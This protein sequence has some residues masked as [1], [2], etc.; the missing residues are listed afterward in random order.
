MLSKFSF[1][2]FV[3]VFLVFSSNVFAQTQSDTQQTYNNMLADAQNSAVKDS[4]GRI[5]QISVKLL[6]DSAT[7]I[8]GLNYDNNNVSTVIDQGG[9]S[10]KVRRDE[11][12]N[13]IGYVFPDGG[14]STIIWDRSDPNKP[15]SIGFEITRPNGT[16]D[17]QLF[18]GN[19]SQIAGPIRPR[20]DACS[21]AIN[22]AG[23]AATAAVVACGL[24]P[25]YSC[26]VASYHAYQICNE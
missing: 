11:G 1:L 4:N 13:V 14:Q 12:G 24:G 20:G 15:I 26:A 9:N 7:E 16:N 19:N 8:V 5:T 2:F 25:G 22:A 23:Y 18:S 21:R 17:T 10:I 3:M 6:P